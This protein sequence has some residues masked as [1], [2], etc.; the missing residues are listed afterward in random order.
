MLICLP[1]A[2]VYVDRFSAR[3]LLSL[4]VFSTFLPASCTTVGY[5]VGYAQ[6][7]VSVL[8][9]SSANCAGLD[10][11]HSV[12]VGVVGKLAALP[13]RC[14]TGQF[15]VRVPALRIR[16]PILD[17]LGHV[18]VVVIPPHLRAVV[19]VRHG[20]PVGRVPVLIRP[21]PGLTHQVASRVV[22]VALHRRAAAAALGPVGRV[23][24]PVSQPIQVVTTNILNQL[25]CFCSSQPKQNSA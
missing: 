17:A 16:H 5:S 7:M 24:A 1:L 13:A 18:A 10:L 12:A 8:L 2:S 14:H 21:H 6:T 11:A 22:A 23:H 20:M 3:Q 9:K 15:V 25:K 4:V 19:Q